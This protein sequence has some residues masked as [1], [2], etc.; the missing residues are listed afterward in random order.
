MRFSRGARASCATAGDKCHALKKATLLFFIEPLMKIIY[1]RCRA[2]SA[3]RTR[4]MRCCCARKAA[5][6]F[7]SLRRG[8][9]H[10]V[11]SHTRRDARHAA[12]LCFTMPHATI[13]SPFS[14]HGQTCT[15]PMLMA[16]TTAMGDFRLMV[17]YFWFSPIALRP[18]LVTRAAFPCRR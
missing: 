5:R 7:L 14:R 16:M 11:H 13:R 15:P 2:A 10:C 12:F 8:H 17:G 4:L 1:F 9:R 6:M 18:E 3:M